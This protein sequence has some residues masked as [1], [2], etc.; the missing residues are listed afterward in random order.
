M[1]TIGNL[2]DACVAD[3]LQ[4]MN[5][6]ARDEQDLRIYSWPQM[7][8]NTACGFGG[9]S[10]QAITSAQTVVILG[11]SHDDVVCVY[12]GARFAYLVN[13]P[14]RLFWEDMHAHRIKGQA[15]GWRSRYES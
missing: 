9:L 13:N 11:P 15:E 3:A 14:S 2:I 6:T 7:W 4:K 5:L 1:T 8:A 10:G 12:V